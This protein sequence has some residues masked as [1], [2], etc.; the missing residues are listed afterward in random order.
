MPIKSYK[1][2]FIL[3]VAEVYIMVLEEKLYKR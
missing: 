2:R 3:N 1:D